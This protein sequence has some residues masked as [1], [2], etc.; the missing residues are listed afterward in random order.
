M[1]NEMILWDRELQNNFDNN[2]PGGPLLYK[3]R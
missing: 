3:R 2:I 1:D